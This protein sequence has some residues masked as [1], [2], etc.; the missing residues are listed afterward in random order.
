MKFTKFTI[1]LACAIKKSEIWEIIRQLIVFID[2][3]HTVLKN[4][5]VSCSLHEPQTKAQFLLNKIFSQFFV[6]IRKYLRKPLEKWQIF[7]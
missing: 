5:L 6:K 1:K 4:I 7:V 2:F 3:S